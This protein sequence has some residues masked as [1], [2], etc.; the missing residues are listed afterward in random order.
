[1]SRLL[2]DNYLFEMCRPESVRFDD[3]EIKRLTPFVP[4]QQLL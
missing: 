3:Q 1:M 4:D 2:D